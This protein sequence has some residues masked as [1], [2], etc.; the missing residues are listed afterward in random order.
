MKKICLLLLMC[1]SL[2]GCITSRLE[3]KGSFVPSDDTKSMFVTSEKIKPGMSK[4][5][6]I[7]IFGKPYKSSFYYDKEKQ[8]HEAL[9]Y[10]EHLF[11][12]LWY[13]VNTIFHFENGIL[14]S[15]EQ[16]AECP[17]FES[18]CSCKN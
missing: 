6:V 2:S 17:T 8:L 5:E 16:G 12:K 18:G 9:Y 3:N 11:I 4:S 14:V 15:Q 10:K 7:S 1:L 13:T